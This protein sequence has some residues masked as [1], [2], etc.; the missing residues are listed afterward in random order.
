M[1]RILIVEDNDVLNKAYELILTHKGHEVATAYDGNE[2]LKR[3]ETFN[4]ELILLDIL[5]PNLDGGG[6]LK[7]Y[8]A[9][10]KHPKVK[11]VLLTNLNEEEARVQVNNLGAHD[12]F[13]KAQLGPG[14][15]VDMVNKQFPLKK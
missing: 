5:M 7:A 11:V 9:A 12:Y 8:D 6:F 15:L 1:T 4:P 14:Q 10:H 3:A 2:G 13:L